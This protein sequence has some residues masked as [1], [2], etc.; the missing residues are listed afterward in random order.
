MFFLV[1]YPRTIFSH[2]KMLA[3]VLVSVI[4]LSWVWVGCMEENDEKSLGNTS[5]MAKERANAQLG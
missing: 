1:N 3:H 4:S 2:Q 5:N